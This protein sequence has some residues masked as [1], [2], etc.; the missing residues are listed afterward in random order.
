LTRINFQPYNHQQLYQIVESRL[1]G[2]GAFDSDAIELCARKVSAVSGDARRALDI[3]RQAVEVVEAMVAQ[4][5]TRSHQ[6]TMAIIDIVVKEMTSSGSVV[7]I[8]NASTHQKLFL[9][10][11][12][13][14]LQKAGLPETTFNEVS[15]HHLQL[16]RLHSLSPPTLSALAAICTTLGASRC[17][18]AE[19]SRYDIHQKLRLNVSDGDLATALKADPFFRAMVA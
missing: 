18:L 3:C 15:R 17:I 16:C 9:V 4:K 8:R 19:A 2:T 12:R 10:A 14:Q 5:Q 1:K 11:L 6:V 13:N 7:F